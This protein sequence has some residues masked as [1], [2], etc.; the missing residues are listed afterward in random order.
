M[1]YITSHP[2][3]FA[4]I[5]ISYVLGIFCACYAILSSRTPQGAT[6]W[7]FALLSFPLVTVPVFLIFGRS[8][9]QGY[10]SKR[11]LMDFKV[12]QEFER[13]KAIEAGYI[14]QSD[15]IHL[16][17]AT[18]APGNQPGFTRKNGIELLIDG[19]QTFQ[20][21]LND[22]EKATNYI[23]LQVYIFRADALGL[24]FVEILS[25]K[26]REGLRVTVLNDEIGAKLP[27]SIRDEF[28]RSGVQLGSFNDGKKGRLQ[29]NFR[30]HRKIIVIDGKVA[31]VGGH[32]IGIEYL[33]DSA[34]Y[35]PWRDTHVRLQ[36]PS[37]IAAQLA[38]AKDWFCCNE[39]PLS[40][41][42]KIHLPESDCNVMVLHTGPAD[43]K[44]TCLLAHLALI[45]ASSKRLWIANPYIVPPESL[46]DALILARMRGVDVRVI[47]PSHSDSRTVMLACEVYQERLAQHGIRVFRYLAGFLH[48]KS[49][50]VDETFGVVGSAN[51][52]CRSMFINFEVS[53][54]STEKDFISQMSHMLEADFA[55]S[56]EMH[57]KD[58]EQLSLVHRITTR[59]ANLLA[60]VL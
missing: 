4:Y 15:E 8:K 59:A 16:I 27:Q 21:I 14:P 52:D 20:R 36:G 9:F 28:T 13:L 35:G 46:L 24:Q 49:I 45:N 58:F 57:L 32:N 48:Q 42:W 5:T 34:K 53:V 17:N 44:Q 39:K 37:V 25:R 7:V 40:A 51:F 6:A 54:L 33:G 30:N 43:E 1:D 60:P 26:A 10:N 11:K 31:Y 12:Q 19:D 50:V 3:E 47:F 18:I 23:V 22:I 41:D 56:Q 55:H 2:Y 38:C 29:I